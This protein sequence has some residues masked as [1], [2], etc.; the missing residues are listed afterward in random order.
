MHDNLSVHTAY[1]CVHSSFNVADY[2]EQHWSCRVRIQVNVS[3]SVPR[4]ILLDEGVFGNLMR[5]LMHNAETH[6]GEADVH[7]SVTVIEIPH[8]DAVRLCIK[9]V[10]SAG[11]GH[12]SSLALQAQHGPNFL[13]TK[14]QSPSVLLSSLVGSEHSTFL[15]MREIHMAASL[16]NADITIYF[17]NDHVVTTLQFT[18]QI[19]TCESSQQQPHVESVQ[20][21]PHVEDTHAPLDVPLAITNA[22]DAAPTYAVAS[23]EAPNIA[24]SDTVAGDVPVISTAE[25]FVAFCDDDKAPRAMA[26][27]L[28]R[29][30]AWA[31]AS[32]SCILGATYA[33][34]ASVTDLVLRESEVRGSLNIVCIFDQNMHWSNGS[35]YGT[36]LV[37]ELRASGFNGLIIIRSANDSE[38]SEE[39]YLKLGADGVVSKG[40]A[41][42]DFLPIILE[43]LEFA[44]Q[45]PNRHSTL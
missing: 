16:M 10:N 9:I 7:I 11:P 26:K 25:V 22:S 29:N 15:G 40:V 33:E 20:Q 6:G 32:E 42:P 14:S 27:G 36:S 23:D 28:L 18:A 31:A 37:V 4:A 3:D 34:V 41:V 2:F 17:E 19:V 35:K 30:S 38:A 24:P 45:H 8:V 39:E 44:R 12:A 21:Q 43:L 5:N 13:I 1:I